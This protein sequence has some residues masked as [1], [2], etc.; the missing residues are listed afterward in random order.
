MKLIRQIRVKTGRFGLFLG[1][2]NI[3]WAIFVVMMPTNN[4]NLIFVQFNLLLGLF[5]IYNSKYEY[6]E[7]MIQK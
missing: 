2:F 6:I 4:F 5:C 1:L 7:L 3:I